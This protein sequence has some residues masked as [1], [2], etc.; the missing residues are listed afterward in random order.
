MEERGGGGKRRYTAGGKMRQGR[1]GVEERGGGGEGGKEGVHSWR[2]QEKGGR[3]KGKR[4]GKAEYGS[5]RGGGELQ[6][7]G[8]PGGKGQVCVGRI[9][10][11][12]RQKGGKG[13]G[14]LR[15]RVELQGRSFGGQR[16]WNEEEAAQQRF[17]CMGGLVSG[18]ESGMEEFLCA[19]HQGAC[20]HS[21]RGIGK[22]WWSCSAQE[23]PLPTLCLWLAGLGG[24][25]RGS[26][27]GDEWVP[28]CSHVRGSMPTLCRN[29]FPL[30][31]RT[32]P[33]PSLSQRVPVDILLSTFPLVHTPSPLTDT[34]LLASPPQPSPLPKPQTFFSPSSPAQQCA[35]PPT[36]LPLHPLCLYALLA[37][38][39][40]P[41]SAPP[42][43]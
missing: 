25:W 15:G 8:T 11:R 3:G 42:A 7:G 1:A 19:A 33:P 37:G 20:V 27:R 21:P 5:R 29:A 22:A 35:P 6:E 12:S 18:S 14:T 9:L 36:L 13:M 28:S 41:S 38:S 31:A 26:E 10:E 43:R 30:T 16:R 32:F 39:P 24:G 23:G 40:A 2:C 4:K 34:S 17:G